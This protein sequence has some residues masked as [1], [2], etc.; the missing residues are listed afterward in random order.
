MGKKKSLSVLNY[1][2]SYNYEQKG[3]TILKAPDFFIIGAAK[4][5]TTSLATWLSE[6]ELIFVTNPKEPQFFNTDINIPGVKSLVE[7]QSLFQDAGDQHLA[8][9]EASVIYLYSKD[10][11]QNIL[12]FN[13]KSRFIV[14]LRNPLEMA[15]SFHGE[16]LW[17]G[18]ES[19]EDFKLAWYSQND[20]APGQE[21]AGPLHTNKILVQYE[22]LCSLGEQV[23]RLLKTVD[24]Q[25]VLFVL[26]DDLRENSLCEYQRVM[27]FLGVPYDG[28]DQFEIFNKAKRHRNKFLNYTIS[29]IAQLQLHKYLWQ[30]G[31]GLL[32]KI[33]VFNERPYISE[34]MHPKFKKE[35]IEVFRKD[36]VLLSELIGRDLSHWLR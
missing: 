32:K 16:M 12:N 1:F 26:M 31:T 30:P 3:K 20:R 27:Q 7:Y 9:G 25:N 13:P 33:Q 19:I 10:A 18:H 36:V 34:P 24:T 4:C 2:L 35:L 22:K 28:R 23:E 8:V 17:L 5:G 29:I 15:Q 6:H 11:V 21:P 14:M